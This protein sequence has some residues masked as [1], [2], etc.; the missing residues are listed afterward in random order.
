MAAEAAVQ[1]IRGYPDD[2]KAGHFVVVGPT[3]SGK[4]YYAKY[5]V[6]A[7][8]ER[9]ARAGKLAPDGAPPI[10][11]FSGAISAHDWTDPEPDGQPLVAPGHVFTAWNDDTQRAVLE[12]ASAVTAGFVVFD[13]FKDA[14]NFHADPR[15]KQMF[16][17]MRHLGVQLLAVAHT[18]NDVPPVVRDNVTHAL[19]FFTSSLSA[20]RELASVYLSGDIAALRGAIKS[21]PPHAAFKINTRQNTRAVHA[22][23][24]P[25][26]SGLA[27]SGVGLDEG[28]RIQVGGSAGA[29]LGSIGLCGRSVNV[30]GG[31]YHDA[32]RNTQYVQLNQNIEA[33]IRQNQVTYADIRARAA[34]NRELEEERVLHKARLARLEEREELKDLLLSPWLTGGDRDRA[35]LLLAR[36]TGNPKVTPY[37]LYADG[38]DERFMAAHYPQ[39]PYEPRSGPASAVS[40]YA[41]LVTAAATRDRGALVAEGFKA[42][43]PTFVDG[44]RRRVRP[45]APPAGDREREREKQRARERARRLIVHRPGRAQGWRGVAEDPAALRELL[46]ALRGVLRDPAQ[47]TPAAAMPLCLDF[48]RRHFPD[49]FAAEKELAARRLGGGKDPSAGR[50]AR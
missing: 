26:E 15:F 5:L 32:S 34:I 22:A 23:P 24:P 42:F 28:D 37:N 39:I 19:I 17:A 21:L 7:A 46:A 44:L 11:V 14:M 43:A 40:C 45:R 2:Y 20:I 13:D 4:T 41:P 3:G 1:T 38:A 49:D 9:M 27:T 6:R 33:Q 31:A 18:P 16:R 50:G 35:A 30:S 48:L 47:A 12:G 29:E 25:S 10:Y 36:A 8:S